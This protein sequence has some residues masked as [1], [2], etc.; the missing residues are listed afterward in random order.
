MA[1]PLTGRA[2]TP[3]RRI[4]WLLLLLAVLAAHGCITAELA[5]RMDRLASEAAMPERLQAVYVRELQ[6]AAPPVVA[7][8]PVAQPKPLPPAA[9]AASAPK[10]A[11]AAASAPAAPP[12]EP[13]PSLAQAEPPPAPASA[14]PEA[15]PPDLVAA[16]TP[17][18]APLPEPGPEAE[19][20][21]SPEPGASA[22]PF[23]WPGATRLS[24]KLTGNV[25]GE[26]HGDAQV[27]WLREGL[28]YQ[29]HVDV[30]VGLPIAPLLTRRSSSEGV[31]TEQGLEPRRYDEDT[32][33]A[34]RDRRRLT[35]RFDPDAV[36]LPDG[37]RRERWPGTQDAA[38]QFV[39]LSWLFTTRP[40]LLRE[41]GTIEFGLALPR[42]VDRWTYD[43]LGE[44]PVTTL[45][46]QVDA[47]H[48]KPRRL[49]RPGGELV[50]EIWFAPTLRYLPA[51]I[52][53]Q[54][55]EQTFV[56]LV[57]S[58]KPELGAP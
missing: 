40:E 43:V 5:D 1:G 9:P 54:Q 3:R 7:P 45:F 6:P 42:S 2:T 31:L 19:A 16:L 55:D 11:P 32:K 8:A 29:V 25:R 47:F 10:Q 35:L 24:Y 53:I 12:V 30:T 26:V 17:A 38:S 48:L 52:R 50:A 20:A 36:V 34:F 21:S 14:P 56:D 46:G 44:E 57:L 49:S 58:R 4:A 18:S 22:P 15:P 27:E 13:E 39:Q 33:Q 23:E 51:R 28:R 37:R 41:G